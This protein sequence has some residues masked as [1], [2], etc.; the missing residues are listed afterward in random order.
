MRV[1]CIGAIQN[2]DPER[3]TQVTLQSQRTSESTQSRAQSTQ[4]QIAASSDFLAQ[5][6][7]GAM[8]LMY[9]QMQSQGSPSSGASERVHAKS[10]GDVREM[11]R[12]ILLFK[13]TR[14]APG[15]VHGLFR[16]IDAHCTTAD[17][18]GA[19]SVEEQIK[20]CISVFASNR[21]KNF[22]VPRCVRIFTHPTRDIP[23]LDNGIGATPRR[24]AYVSWVLPMFATIFSWS[25]NAPLQQRGRAHQAP[26]LSMLTPPVPRPSGTDVRAQGDHRAVLREAGKLHAGASAMYFDAGLTASRMP[27]PRST[28]TPRMSTSAGT[29]VPPA[30]SHRV[31]TCSPPTIPRSPK[32]SWVIVSVPSSEPSCAYWGFQ[33]FGSGGQGAGIKVSL[34]VGEEVKDDDYLMQSP[35][36]AI[37]S[38]GATPHTGPMSIMRGY[39][40]DVYGSRLSRSTGRR[41]WTPKTE[42]DA[43]SVQ[44]SKARP[45]R[46]IP[47][48][49]QVTA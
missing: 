16:R 45:C 37:L 15:E 36:L 35:P 1:R 43:R 4:P 32:Y 25:L 2:I 28:K 30:P 11:F 21:S 19:D 13:G 46:A 12:L 3:T 38:P 47:K 48:G 7:A 39:R 10:I 44:A 29:L 40:G 27:L 18:T 17:R 14:N 5:A 22:K 24:S 49:S 6:M 23:S 33:R 26:K 8:Q 41:V 31:T 20:I 9:T 42:S 34:K